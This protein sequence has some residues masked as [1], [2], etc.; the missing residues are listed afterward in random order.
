[1][2]FRN[3]TTTELVASSS[4]NNSGDVSAGRAALSQNDQCVGQAWSGGKWVMSRRSMV[5]R[6]KHA[7]ER[8]RWTRYGGEFACQWE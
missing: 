6:E 2:S 5:R 7:R 8:A 4:S 1:M 3:L